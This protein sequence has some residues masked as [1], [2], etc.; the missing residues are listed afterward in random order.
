[1]VH[2]LHGIH[3]DAGFLISREGDIGKDEQ[4]LGAVGDI[5]AAIEAH[6][7]YAAF[8]A[9]SLAERVG[10]ADGLVVNLVGQMR[11]QQRDCQRNRRLDLHAEFL[12]VVVGRH[13]AVDLG[14]RRHLIFF[15]QNAAPF[16]TGQHAIIYASPTVVLDADIAGGN[17]LLHTRT[18]DRADGGDNRLLRTALV[19]EGDDHRPLGRQMALISR[20]GDMLLYAQ[21]AEIH[22]R[23]GILHGGVPF[24][25]PDHCDGDGISRLDA[26][27]HI[28]AS[29][30]GMVNAAGV[31]AGGFHGDG[32]GVGGSPVENAIVIILRARGGGKGVD[33][34]RGN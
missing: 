1:M 2:A 7:L 30:C 24:I 15:V 14:C 29:G 21:E 28:A 3:L 33:E 27:V 12:V 22:G 26:N 31:E 9:S 4:G 32:L 17:E 8:L 10:K 23:V 11:R 5:E 18:K 20:T 34:Y 13:Q 25:G 19:V 6:L 16:E